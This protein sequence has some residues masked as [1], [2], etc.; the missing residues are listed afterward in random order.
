M[1]SFAEEAAALVERDLGAAAAMMW[2]A[3]VSERNWANSSCKA[4]RFRLVGSN[5]SQRSSWRGAFM[6]WSYCNFDCFPGVVSSKAKVDA[7]QIHHYIPGSWYRNTTKHTFFR[8]KTI[9][10]ETLE[11]A[12][13][14]QSSIQR[15]SS[16]HRRSR[17]GQTV[18]IVKLSKSFGQLTAVDNLDLV[19][20]FGGRRCDECDVVKTV[21]FFGIECV[22]SFKHYIY[23]FLLV[24]F[25][26]W[27]VGC[28][29]SHPPRFFDVLTSRHP[30]PH[31]LRAQSS[32]HKPEQKHLTISYQR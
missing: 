12:L 31:C 32:F 19:R 18:E 17:N 25:F 2:E 29:F 11:F 8:K 27:V 26:R 24:C 23:M 10:K 4:N 13:M 5:K 3:Q 6:V 7:H 22:F 1:T 14:S 28:G 15:P 20:G 30:D 21:Y 9:T 16:D